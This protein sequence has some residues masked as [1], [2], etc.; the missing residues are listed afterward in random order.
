MSLGHVIDEWLRVAEHEDSTRQTYLGYIERTIGPALGSMAISKLST[1]H[2]KT[3]YVE[4]RRCR[5]RCDRKPFVEHKTAGE[6]D[7]AKT[8]CAPH[9]QT[10]GGVDGPADPLRYQRCVVG[11]G[12]V[13]LAGVQ[14]CAGRS[15][16][17]TEAPGA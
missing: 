13:G 10:D 15:T 9:V 8:R 1:R 4:L 5:I 16:A 7:C 11:G 6:H 2:L 3:L 17:Q 12:A 14:S